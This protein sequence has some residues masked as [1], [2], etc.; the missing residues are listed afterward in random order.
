LEIVAEY[1]AVGGKAVVGVW[2]VLAAFLT[3]PFY[4][5]DKFVDVGTR[6]V[7]SWYGKYGYR[8]ISYKPLPYLH[9]K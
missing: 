1:V 3:P 8:V 6:I 9:D 7:D 2:G 4:K 5:L